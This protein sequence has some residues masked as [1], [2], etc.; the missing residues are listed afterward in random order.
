[1]RPRTVSRMQSRAMTHRPLNISRRTRYAA[2]SDSNYWK[3]YDNQRFK[4]YGR[5]LHDA[6]TSEPSRAANSYNSVR[7]GMRLIRFDPGAIRSAD[8]D[9]HSSGSGCNTAL[10]ADSL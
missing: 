6:G 4:P 9:T 1:M 8:S 10:G 2:S 5:A 3:N 7:R